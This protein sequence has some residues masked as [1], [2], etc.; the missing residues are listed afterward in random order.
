MDPDVAGWASK[1]FDKMAEQS[2]RVFVV[3]REGVELPELEKKEQNIQQQKRKWRNDLKF[4]NIEGPPKKMLQYSSSRVRKAIH[5]GIDVRYIEDLPE[6][7]RGFLRGN[8]EIVKAYRE[9]YKA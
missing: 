6:T 5:E 3:A 4:V 8:P 2:G 7:L 9:A 1:V